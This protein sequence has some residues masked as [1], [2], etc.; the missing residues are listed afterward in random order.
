MQYMWIV[1]QVVKDMWWKVHRIGVGSCA[2]YV[3]EV[4][5]D[6][7]WK[8]YRIFGGCFTEYMVEFALCT[9]WC[10]LNRICYA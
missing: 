9:I 2:E 7:S 8:F 10:S 1:V 6:M 4:V 5:K 3:M